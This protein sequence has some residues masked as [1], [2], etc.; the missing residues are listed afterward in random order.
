MEVILLMCNCTMDSNRLMDVSSKDRTF[1]CLYE[2]WFVSCRKASI[3]VTT[4][5]YQSYSSIGTCWKN[6]IRNS[7]LKILFI[8]YLSLHRKF[9]CLFVSMFVKSDFTQENVSTFFTGLIIVGL[10][11]MKGKFNRIEMKRFSYFWLIEYF[12]KYFFWFLDII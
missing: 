7:F 11:D 6:K 1:F 5:R 12:L 3:T 9:H 8:A 2:S 4:D 10:L